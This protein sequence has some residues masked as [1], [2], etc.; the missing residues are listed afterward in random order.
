MLKNPIIILIFHYFFYFFLEKGISCGSHVVSML[1]SVEGGLFKFLLAPPPVCH[2]LMHVSHLLRTARAAI[3]FLTLFRL[4]FLL[5]FFVC[6]SIYILI[7]HHI[8]P[9]TDTLACHV[10][11]QCQL[12]P[13]VAALIGQQP[14]RDDL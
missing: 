3:C 9:P 6:C 5:L 13:Q 10:G 8:L 11:F 4:M 12:P 1:L 2:E 7:A 14:C